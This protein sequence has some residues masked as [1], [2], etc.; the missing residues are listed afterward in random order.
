MAYRE[1]G[2]ISEDYHEAGHVA[3]KDGQR[4][5]DLK[6]GQCQNLEAAMTLR[7]FVSSFLVAFCDTWA[8]ER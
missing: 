8:S 5:V 4:R 2:M 3:L 1:R 6:I 7:A